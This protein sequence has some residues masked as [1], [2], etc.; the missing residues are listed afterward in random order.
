MCVAVK[1]GHMGS[2]K[3]VRDKSSQGFTVGKGGLNGGQKRPLLPP[4]YSPW[5]M[6]SSG[7]CNNALIV[8]WMGVIELFTQAWKAGARPR[9]C[10]QA[11]S[12]ETD[13][14]RTE[15]SESFL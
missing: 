7:G 15:N 4:A 1:T 12:Q 6:G 2:V 5:S 13:G 9:G 11:C 10:D 14:E 8:P 3:W